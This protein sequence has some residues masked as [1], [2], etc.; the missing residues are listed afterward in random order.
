MTRR[1]LKAFI[2]LDASHKVVASSL[3]YRAQMPKEGRWIEIPK[4][5]CCS[6]TTTIFPFTCLT[7]NVTVAADTTAVFTYTNCWTGV[8][9]KQTVTATSATI[10]GVQGTI[11]YVITAGRGAVTVTV[12]SICTTTTTSSTTT[13]TTT[14]A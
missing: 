5:E 1:N 12:A 11:S 14:H 10:C 6:P 13:T 7:Y 3:I 9:T 2:R 8:V 4:S